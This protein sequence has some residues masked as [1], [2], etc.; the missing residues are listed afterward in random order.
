MHIFVQCIH[1]KNKANYLF[2]QCHQTAATVVESNYTASSSAFI[3]KASATQSK[4]CI[5]SVQ[6]L[7]QLS[8]LFSVGR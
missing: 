6:C 4:G 2:A 7:G 1:T 8:L 3:V 5:S